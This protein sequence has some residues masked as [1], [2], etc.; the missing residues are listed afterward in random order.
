MKSEISKIDSRELMP[1][2]KIAHILRYKA[3]IVRWLT[4]LEELAIQRILDGEHIEGFRVGEGRTMRKWALSD[5][6]IKEELGGLGLRATKEQLRTI[7]EIE[8]ELGGN[9]S[10]I[11]HLIEKPKGKLK[12]IAIENDLTKLEM[13]EDGD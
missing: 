13:I 7:V 5:E 8:K 2:G 10:K 4:S 6:A 9:K 3:L 11:Q 12:L 1:N